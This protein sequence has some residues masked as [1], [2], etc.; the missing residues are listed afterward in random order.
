[1]FGLLDL[2][3]RVAMVR[4]NI[5][6]MIAITII[7]AI[8]ITTGIVQILLYTRIQLFTIRVWYWSRFLRSTLLPV[9]V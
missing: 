6:V 4:I 8:T 1:M 5:Q 2:V 9:V 3:C 7:G